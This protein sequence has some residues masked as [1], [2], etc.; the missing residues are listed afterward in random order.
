MALDVVLPPEL[1]VLLPCDVVDCTE[2]VV[3]D[4]VVED[5]VV[6]A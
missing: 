5:V 2:S 6:S 3:V 1:D 4:A